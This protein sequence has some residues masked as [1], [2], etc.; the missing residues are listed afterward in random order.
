MH[1]SFLA[2][3]HGRQANKHVNY[4][5]LEPIF[6]LSFFNF[7]SPTFDC[8]YDNHCYFIL[9]EL[10]T[11]LLFRLPTLSLSLSLF[12]LS[13][14]CL[15][16]RLLKYSTFF[17]LPTTPLSHFAILSTLCLAPFQCCLDPSSSVLLHLLA[18]C[19]PLSLS[20]LFFTLLLLLSLYYT[21]DCN[22]NTST[23]SNTR[24]SK[25]NSIR[26]DIYQ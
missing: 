17:C 8:Y 4:K 12:N 9:L 23:N 18:T 10:D 15:S 3:L 7:L 6:L 21:A 5:L 2:A 25:R 26:S 20:S 19:L 16:L 14:V 1:R 22:K 24:S 13:L 11:P